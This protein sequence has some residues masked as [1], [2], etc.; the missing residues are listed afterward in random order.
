MNKITENQSNE[1]SF[2]FLCIQL[3]CQWNYFEVHFECLFETSNNTRVGGFGDN[4]LG[5]N[6]VSCSRNTMAG[7]FYFDGFI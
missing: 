4:I 1:N 7:R 6:E 5:T 3:C 2:A